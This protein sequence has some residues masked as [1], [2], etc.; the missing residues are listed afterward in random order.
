MNWSLL[1]SGLALCVSLGTVIYVQ[2]RT[3]RRE[4]TKWRRDT[5]TKAAVDFASEVA[6]LQRKIIDYVVK[7]DADN[8]NEKIQILE[9]LS[10]MTTI[11]LTFDICD[12]DNAFEASLDITG[13]FK[14]IYE[15]LQSEEPLFTKSYED[16]KALVGQ[17]FGTGISAQTI[18]NAIKQDLNN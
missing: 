12:A 8:S 14:K 10:K 1:L 16:R 13:Q 18:R 17:H 11:S 3:D 4:L 6:N 9:T 15:S 2:K 5:A 7:Q